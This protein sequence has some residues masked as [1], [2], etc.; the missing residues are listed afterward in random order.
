MIAKYDIQPNELAWTLNPNAVVSKT[1]GQSIFTFQKK[2][3]LRHCLT[4]IN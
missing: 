2:G 4:K 3:G 1:A